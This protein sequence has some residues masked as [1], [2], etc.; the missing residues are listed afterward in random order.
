MT[1]QRSQGLSSAGCNSKTR[2]RRSMGE[3]R[4]TSRMSYRRR[5]T[6]DSGLANTLSK[7]LRLAA[8]SSSRFVE[9]SRFAAGE[10]PRGNVLLTWTA[11]SLLDYAGDSRQTKR[12][13]SNPGL[14]QPLIALTLRTREHLSRNCYAWDARAP[15][16]AILLR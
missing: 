6:A 12:H 16:N 10:A 14:V 4:R 15:V 1:A 8:V 3:C 2:H 7:T 11:E 13:S 9:L 5:E